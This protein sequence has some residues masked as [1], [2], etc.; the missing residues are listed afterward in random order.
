MRFEARAGAGLRGAAF[1]LTTKKEWKVESQRVQERRQLALQVVRG[2]C[3]PRRPV[4]GVA[5]HHACERGASAPAH[6]DQRPRRDALRVASKPRR[7]VAALDRVGSPAGSCAARSSS[8]G[9]QKVEGWAAWRAHPAHPSSRPQTAPQTRNG[10]G[11]R[12][13]ITLTIHVSLC[14]LGRPLSWLEARAQAP[15]GC[16]PQ[17]HDTSRLI[18]ARRGQR[19]TTL[20]PAHSLRQRRCSLPHGARRRNWRNS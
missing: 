15:A 19:H 17:P 18:A 12:T 5:C 20:H 9:A 11:V 10:N 2:T 8:T 4:A 6:K 3:E 14:S 7:K 1:A 16:R 13:S